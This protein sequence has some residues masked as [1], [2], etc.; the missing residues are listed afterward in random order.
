[1]LL[2]LNPSFTESAKRGLFPVLNRNERGKWEMA[3]GYYYT[4]DHLGSVREMTDSSGTIVARYSYDPYGRTSL[5]S[6]TNLATKQFT[7][8]YYHAAS[9]LNLTM[10]RA[11]DPNSGR[12]LSR[13]PIAEQGGINLY[14]Y[15]RENPLNMIDYLGL[16]GTWTFTISPSK[17]PAGKGD[18]HRR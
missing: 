8:D 1:M 4:R 13:D 10:Y 18:R 15:V 3:N 16:E 6:G 7:G 12:W 5:V 9:G 14:A 2:A 17:S 11:Y